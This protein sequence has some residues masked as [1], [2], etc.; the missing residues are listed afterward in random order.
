M[1]EDKMPRPP[2]VKPYNLDDVISALNGVMPYDWSGFIRKR[3]FDVNPR[4][5]LGGIELGGWKLVYT[6]QPNDQV[7]AN[8]NRNKVVDATFSLGLQAKEDGVVGDVV[9]GMSAEKAGLSPGIKSWPSTVESLRRTSF[10]PRS[11]TQKP[12]RN[13]WN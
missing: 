11:R 13:R 12:G 6:D 2:V 9:F 3:V 7:R 1:R 8:E 5:P 4:A 10:A